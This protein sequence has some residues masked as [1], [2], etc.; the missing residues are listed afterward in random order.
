MDLD[1]QILEV[2]ADQLDK[3]LGEIKVDY[4]ETAKLA[5]F[6]EAMVGV[7]EHWDHVKQ[8]KELGWRVPE[9]HPDLDPAHEALLRQW[10]VLAGWLNDDL[11]ALATLDGVKDAARIWLANERDGAY[12]THTGPRLAA[13]EG[14][15][16][17]RDLLANLTPDEEKYL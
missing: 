7:D 17:R 4:V 14:L 2:K 8:M 10:A 3:E 12:L 1:I 5:T 9:D 6:T 13:A 11:A 16:A 15:N